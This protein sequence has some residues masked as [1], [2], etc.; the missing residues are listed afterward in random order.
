MKLEREVADEFPLHYYVWKNNI[1]ALNSSIPDLKSQL[2]RLD[3]RGRT[4]L[5]LAVTLDFVE[6]ARILI[7][8]GAN[9]NVENAEGWT[10][11]FTLSY[12]V[13]QQKLTVYL[14]VV[15]EASSTGNVE[16][17]HMILE[18]RDHQRHNSRM[19]GVPQLLQKLKDVR[20]TS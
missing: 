14:A 12:P 18:K 4:P 9:V 5:M 13:L 11:K 16:L 20:I 7:D 6:C 10:G 8:H 2:E 17:L 15:Q 3:P 1:S 19:L